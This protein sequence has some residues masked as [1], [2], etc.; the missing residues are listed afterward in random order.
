MCGKTMLIK[1]L[2]R[3]IRAMHGSGYPACP[4]CE[5]ICRR[6][7]TLDRH[8]AEKHGE[9]AGVFGTVECAVCGKS[10]RERALRDHFRSRACVEAR[11][12]CSSVADVQ[13]RIEISIRFDA[14]TVL[15]PLD[16]IAELF[17]AVDYQ[18]IHLDPSLPPKLWELRGLAMRTMMRRSNSTS[19]G[20]MEWLPRALAGMA[21][22]DCYIRLFGSALIHLKALFSIHGYNLDDMF[23]ADSNAGYLLQIF[24]RHDRVVPAEEMV[25]RECMNVRLV[26]TA[27]CIEQRNAKH[28]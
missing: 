8:M 3:H 20:L 23:A 16:V 2:S 22:V 11:A 28:E 6:K 19:E 4:L 26:S 5:K 10:V 12:K 1:T 25:E 7:D 27:S 15:E 21:V 24:A 9:K 14:S 13:T 17:S 18:Y